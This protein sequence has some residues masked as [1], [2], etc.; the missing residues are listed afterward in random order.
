[1]GLINLFIG[2]SALFIYWDCTRNHIGKIPG[3]KGILNNSAGVWAI[4]TCLLWIV[5]FPL[6]LLNRK[7]LKQKAVSSP[8]IVSGAKRTVIL[9]VLFLI[10]ALAAAGQFSTFLVPDSNSLTSEVSGV[11]KTAD[12]TVV[13]INLTNPEAGNM[14]IENTYIPVRVDQI[15]LDNQI[16]VLNVLLDEGSEVWTIQKDVQQDETFL[17]VLTKPDGAQFQLSFIREII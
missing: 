7:A 5:V 15:D 11:W 4:G 9:G 16:V 13:T 17:L 14:Q 10:S 8:Q 12:N 2:L 1:M 3:E 6:Y